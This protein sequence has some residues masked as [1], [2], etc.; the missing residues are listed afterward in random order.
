MNSTF[1]LAILC[2][3]CLLLWSINYKL[4]GFEKT[5]IGALAVIIALGIRILSTL[6]K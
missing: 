5:V 3:F 4:F 6:D 1:K 2:G